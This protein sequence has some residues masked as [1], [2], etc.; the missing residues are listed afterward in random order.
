M[1]ADGQTDISHMARIRSAKLSKPNL[2]S[3]YRT[4]A[5]AKVASTDIGLSDIDAMIGQGAATGQIGPSGF[6]S[7]NLIVEM[8]PQKEFAAQEKVCQ[9]SRYY[10]SQAAKNFKRNSSN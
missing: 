7:R 8:P 4:M 1:F 6:S 2:G 3:S 5:F 10:P 9:R